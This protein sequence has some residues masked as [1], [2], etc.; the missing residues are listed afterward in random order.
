MNGISMSSKKQI[1]YKIVIIEMPRH[2]GKTF[3]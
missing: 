1:S 3:F 2:V